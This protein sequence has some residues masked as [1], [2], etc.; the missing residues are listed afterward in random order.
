[1]IVELF[2]CGGGGGGSSSTCGGG[3]DTWQNAELEGGDSWIRRREGVSTW[4]ER[5]HHAHVPFPQRINSMSRP[6][7]FL[8]MPVLSDLVFAIQFHLPV[9]SVKCLQEDVDKN[10]LVVG[11][12]EL[13]E[14]P[15]TTTNLKVR[16]WIVPVTYGKTFLRAL[17]LR[18][19]NCIV[20][21]Y[22]IFNVETNT[23]N[24]G[25]FGYQHTFLSPD[26]LFFSSGKWIK[27]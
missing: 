8:L 22:F 27:I 12:Y 3:L 16:E 7:L 11:E 23:K 6:Y 26:C 1:M 21:F 17:S 2:T 15:R 20:I 19:Q 24:T 18:K 4:Q 13:T 5:Q 9:N 14:E 25:S 10:V